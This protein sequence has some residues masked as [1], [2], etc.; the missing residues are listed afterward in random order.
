[1][2]NHNSNKRNLLNNNLNMMILKKIAELESEVEDHEERITD[3][4]EEIQ[5]KD[6]NIEHYQLNKTLD[7]RKYIKSKL[8]SHS[9]NQTFKT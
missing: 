3:N 8:I 1:M 4:T 7:K 5:S 2:K 6:L 9:Y